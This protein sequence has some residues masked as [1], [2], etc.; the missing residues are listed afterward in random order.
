MSGPPE[1]PP[2]TTGSRMTSAEPVAVA[3]G[4][5][6][7]GA[8]E[9]D[10]IAAG[11]DVSVLIPAWDEEDAIGGVVAAALAG[12]RSAGFAAECLVCVDARTRDATAERAREAGARVVVQRG[13]GLTGAVLQVAAEARA[14]VCAVLDGDGQHGGGAIALLAG[15][16]VAGQVDLCI[17][18]RERRSLRSGFGRGLRG[19]TRYA[20]ARLLGLAARLA[21]GRSVSDPLTGMFACRRRDLLALGSSPATAPPEGYKLLL[22]L[23]VRVPSDRVREIAVPFFPRQGG[24]SKLGRRVVALTLRQLCGLLISR[25][26]VANA[27]RAPSIEGP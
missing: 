10:V 15:P 1:P 8:T 16:V 5:F 3:P 9:R 20:G 18:I 7:S 25:R 26:A 19:A 27:S 23:I 2:T 6:E 24:D 14:T 22:G 21:T 4:P 13:R 12:C 17:G 11:I